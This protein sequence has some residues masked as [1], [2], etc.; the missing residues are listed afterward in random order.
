VSNKKVKNFSISL[1]RYKMC[2]YNLRN[3]FSCSS[4]HANKVTQPRYI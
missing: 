1:F 4:E 2:C 3:L